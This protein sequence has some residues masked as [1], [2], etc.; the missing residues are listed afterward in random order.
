VCM[1]VC[2]STCVTLSLSLSLCVCVCMCVCTQAIA[3]I[4]FVNLLIA[5]MNNTYQTV[6]NHA[7][8]EYLFSRAQIIWKYDKSHNY[9]MPPPFNLIILLL[10]FLGTAFQSLWKCVCASVCC[11]CTQ[12]GSVKP[13]DEKTRRQL[14]RK[15]NNMFMLEEDEDKHTNN[16]NNN[17]NNN[18]NNN[19]NNTQQRSRRASN[20]QTYS[21]TQTHTH[22]NEKKNT[23]QRTPITVQ[24]KGNTPRKAHKKSQRCRRCLHEEPKKSMYARLLKVLSDAYNTQTIHHPKHIH[25]H[26]R[27]NININLIIISCTALTNHTY[28]HTERHTHIGRMGAVRFVY[29]F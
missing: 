13:T 14:R 27:S 21:Y 2:M 24:H 23:T 26:T 11:V 4:L 12:R 19:N 9:D 22:D 16:N 17:H 10:V 28:T 25:A 6:Q 15:R 7:K 8:D 5:M 18:N 1:Y 3:A 29:V 20:S